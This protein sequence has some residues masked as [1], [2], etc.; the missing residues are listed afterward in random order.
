[1][2]VGQGARVNP[3]PLCPP[4]VLGALLDDPARRAALGEAGR[5]RVIE[6]GWLWPEVGKR[7]AALLSEAGSRKRAA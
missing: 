3:K 2:Q 1:M 6:R 5:Q 7:L 4:G